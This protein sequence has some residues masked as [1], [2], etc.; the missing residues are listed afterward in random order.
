LIGNGYIS[1][2]KGVRSNTMF[3][4]GLFNGET[5]S[6]SHRAAI[7]ASFAVTVT[8]SKTTGVLMDVQ[9]GT[10]FRRGNVGSQAQYELRWYA[11][12][13]LR[14]LYV[15]ELEVNVVEGDS[16]TLN[17]SQNT[18]STTSDFKELSRKFVNNGKSESV[19]RITTIPETSDGPTSTVCVVADIIPS[20][21]TVHK[22][23]SGKTFTFI[24]ATRTSLDSEQVES[25][26]TEDYTSASLMAQQ[27]TL[28]SSHV[29]G[30]NAVWES[31]I[32]IGGRP[33]VSTAVNASLYSI[34]SSV[35]DDWPYGLA[36]GGLTNY[37]NGHSFWDTETWMYP[38]LMFLQPKI[39]RSLIQYRFDRL[40]GARM[41]AKSYNPPW[42]GT[43]FPWESAFSGV[44]TCPT[45]AATGLRE[46]HISGDISLGVWQEWCMRKDI[47]WLRTIGYPI[48]QG[49]AGEVQCASHGILSGLPFY[50]TLDFWLSRSVYETD[51][52]GVETA[53][54]KDIIPPDEY[55]DHVDDSVYSNFVASQALRFAVQAST[56]LNA[57]CD[58]CSKYQK[59]ADDLVI[60]F[61][62]VKGIHPEYKNYPGDTVKQA[63][64]VLLH[65][66]L[67]MEMDETVRRSDLE[68]YSERTDLHGPAMTW[69]MHSIGFLDLEDPISAGKYFN[70]SFQDN[71][72]PP[73]Q[74]WTETV[75][76]K[77]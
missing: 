38:P 29:E 22:V 41:K 20:S 58:S 51:S 11:H 30:W 18:L 64:V 44:E 74:V 27:N 70:M 61:D 28:Y 67:G 62:P 37:Y 5:T 45:F 16:V 66:P 73:L 24:S 69:G 23:D 26:A 77:L 60:L 6:P 65:Y 72:H 35:R 17:L 68:Y 47:N 15:M 48:L 63:D 57:T 7:P 4:S 71:L 55:V 21:F 75:S 1:H 14:S 3:V 76:L 13:T 54:I 39:S 2:A 59:L 12:R 50:F 36:P 49:V 53:H 46:D 19:C 8:N 33:D 52:N 25:A 56:V 43:M 31:G 9:S 34:L 32:E 10:Y 42:A 40:E